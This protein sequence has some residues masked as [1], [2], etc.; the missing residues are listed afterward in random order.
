[1]ADKKPNFGVLEGVAVYAKIA[2]ADNKYE[3]KDTEY[4][5]GVIVDEDVADEWESVFKKQPPKKIKVSD[6]EDKYKFPCPIEGA[7]NVYQITLKKDAVI[8][9]VEFMPEYRPKVF[10]DMNNGDRIDI[11][12]S[13]LISN[14][15]AVKVSYSISENKYGTFARLRNVLV[16][17]DTF[18][19]YESKGVASGDEFGSKSVKKEPAKE[20]ATNARKPKVKEQP[21]QE[22]EDDDS[23]DAPF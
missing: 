18:K 7:K 15:S 1:M 23:Q 8:D 5:I 21:A 17:E 12:E 10:L 13:R 4:S 9:G 3:S 11:T 20:S 14:G 16:E 2:Q 19:E 22:P 6:F